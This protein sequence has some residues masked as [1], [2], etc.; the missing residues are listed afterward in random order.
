MQKEGGDYR[1]L[2][3][4]QDTGNPFALSG[5]KG[6]AAEQHAVLRFRRMC[7]KG[8]YTNVEQGR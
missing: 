2:Y 6:S 7:T 5:D 3:S 1:W 8:T 4:L